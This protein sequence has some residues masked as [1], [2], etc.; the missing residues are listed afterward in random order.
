MSC[1]VLTSEFIIMLSIFITGELWPPD[2]IESSIFN[3]TQV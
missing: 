2:G 1:I 3:S